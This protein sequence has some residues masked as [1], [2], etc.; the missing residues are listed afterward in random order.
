MLLK[1][2]QEFDSYG[3]KYKW[4]QDKMQ[5][6]ISHQLVNIVVSFYRLRNWNTRQ[7]TPCGKL[8]T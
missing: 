7:E 4:S 3:N 6:L 8:V 2:E 5:T 1:F